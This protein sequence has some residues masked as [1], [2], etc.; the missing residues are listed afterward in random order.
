MKRKIKAFEVYAEKNGLKINPDRVDDV[1]NGLAMKKEKFGIAYCPCI[2]TYVH[3]VD[4][5][6]PCKPLRENGECLCGLF[7]K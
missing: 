3:S 6:C 1:I 2:P 5:I 7:I 4:T